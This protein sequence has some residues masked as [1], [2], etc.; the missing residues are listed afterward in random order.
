[1]NKLSLLSRPKSL[2]FMFKSSTEYNTTAIYL[3]FYLLQKKVS[4]LSSSSMVSTLFAFTI[5]RL[6]TFSTDKKSKFSQF[7]VKEIF[8]NQVNFPQSS[9]FS[10]VKQIFHS[11]GNF[12]QSKTF[13]QTKLR[14]VL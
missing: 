13:L 14:K 10:A 3:R 9:T 2:I 1:M 6:V 5:V 7:T 4:E 12:Q 11:E 8:H